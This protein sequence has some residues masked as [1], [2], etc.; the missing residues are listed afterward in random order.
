MLQ[1][2]VANCIPAFAFIM[3]IGILLD[4]I[5]FIIVGTCAPMTKKPYVFCCCGCCACLCDPDYVPPPEEGDEG[6]E[7]RGVI[8]KRAR[9]FLAKARR[10]GR[11][12]KE[13][14]FAVPMDF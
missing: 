8:T 10:A 7:A 11:F 3:F 12:L 14:N 4:W 5:D 1:Y 13:A 6:T 2:A 9:T